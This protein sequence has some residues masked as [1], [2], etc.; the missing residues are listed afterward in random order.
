MIPTTIRYQVISG[1]NMTNTKS[2][3]RVLRN[4]ETLSLLG[5]SNTTFYRRIKDGLLPPPFNLGCRAVGW[6]EHEIEKVIAARVAG[7]TDEEV[8]T[9]VSELVAA[10]KSAV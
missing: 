5:I 2:A 1:V 4:K 9:L 3:F 7:K 8:K 6:L 10:R